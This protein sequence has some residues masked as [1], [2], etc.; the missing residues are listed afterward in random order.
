MSDQTQKNLENIN[1]FREYF[2]DFNN[3]ERKLL[4]KVSLVKAENDRFGNQFHKSERIKNWFFIA[5]W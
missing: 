5:A 1:S 4:G 3:D 2:Y